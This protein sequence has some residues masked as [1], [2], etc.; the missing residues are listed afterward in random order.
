[1]CC[2]ERDTFHSCFFFPPPLCIRTNSNYTYVYV[3]HVWPSTLDNST[4][5]LQR[6]VRFCTN[7]CAV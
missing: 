7:R 1:M 6:H 5:L 4:L 3:F 2:F